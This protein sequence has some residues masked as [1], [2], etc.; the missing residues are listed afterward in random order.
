MVDTLCCV[1]PIL[2]EKHKTT[3]P[4]FHTS[5]KDSKCTLWEKPKYF[6]SQNVWLWEYVADKWKSNDIF[7]EN[8]NPKP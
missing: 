7:D 6:L 5:A 1:W 8:M 4:S 3:E 2:N